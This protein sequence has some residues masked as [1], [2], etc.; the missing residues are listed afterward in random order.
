MP[1]TIHVGARS[2]FVTA[3]AWIFIL[4]A[5]LVSL[6]TLLQNAHVASLLPGLGSAGDSMP[7]PW[8]AALL[9][10]HLP[11]VLGAG[12]VLSLTTLASAAGLLMRHDWGRRAFIG[13]LV[14]AI[15]ANLAGLWLQHEVV[16]SVVDNTLTSVPPQALGVFDGF[17]TAA[18]VMGVLV[19][20]TACGLLGWIIRALM[21]ARVRQE[22]A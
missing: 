6:S 9:M 14:M 7:L 16:R 19:T 17:V 18:R 8:L 11:W 12:F 4:L 2:R 10:R 22:F 20:L 15:V 13:L 1:H 21:S 3:T 5:G